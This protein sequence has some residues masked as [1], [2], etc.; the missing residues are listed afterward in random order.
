MINIV[1]ELRNNIVEGYN[2][3]DIELLN[4][5]ISSIVGINIDLEYIRRLNKYKYKDNNVCLYVSWCWYNNSYNYKCVELIV[6]KDKKEYN[7]II[8]YSVGLKIK[9]NIRIR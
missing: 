6:Y 5:C 3:N 1:N 4:R 9:E 8:P 7:Y 2:H